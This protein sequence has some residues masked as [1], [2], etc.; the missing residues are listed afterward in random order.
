MRESSKSKEGDIVGRGVEF[1]EFITIG[2]LTLNF[3]IR[4]SSRTRSPWA[5]MRIRY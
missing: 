3:S 2:L 1:I 4:G 5:L